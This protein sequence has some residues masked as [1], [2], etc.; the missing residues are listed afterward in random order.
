MTVSY[1]LTVLTACQ[2]A[3]YLEFWVRQ[4]M[5]MCIDFHCCIFIV[6]IYLISGVIL[7]QRNAVMVYY[8]Q[9][10]LI[11]VSVTHSTMIQKISLSLMLLVS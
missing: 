8:N 4:I 6:F 7:D 1:T 10:W 2:F 5:V 11:L 9:H 3:K